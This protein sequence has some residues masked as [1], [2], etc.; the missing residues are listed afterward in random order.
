MDVHSEAGGVE[1]LDQP[2]ET[3]R[4]EIELAYMLGRFAV[5]I[6]VGGEHR[7]RLSRS[8]NTLTRPERRKSGSTSPSLL[9]FVCLEA[10]WF[11]V[12]AV[13]EP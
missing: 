6:E 8:A 7:R 4:I 11:D 1:L 3:L 13:A 2:L 5:G 9:A 12:L 10:S